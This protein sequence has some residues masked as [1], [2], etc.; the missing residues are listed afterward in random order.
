MSFLGPKAGSSTA[1]KVSPEQSRALAL[2]LVEFHEA[3]TVPFFSL[4]RSPLMPSLPYSMVTTPQSLVL[5]VNMP[6]V[7]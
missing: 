6:W 2:N 4:S 5:P 1:G 3:G 7:P